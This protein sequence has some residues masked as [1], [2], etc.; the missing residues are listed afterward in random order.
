[1]LFEVFSQLGDRVMWTED[2]T[3]I[4][5]ETQL[6]QLTAAQYKIKLDGKHTTINA[7][8]QFCSEET[9]KTKAAKSQ[10]KKL[11]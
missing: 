11:F 4:P 6:K 3:A 9:G 5:S 8:I 10:V 2:I 1:M 7:V